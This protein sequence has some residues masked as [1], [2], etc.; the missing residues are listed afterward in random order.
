VHTLR[1]Q[2][3]DVTN[4]TLIHAFPS[5]VTLQLDRM[6]V[7][8]LE[9]DAGSTSLPLQVW[10]HLDVFRGDA[11][12]L[13]TAKDHVRKG[14]LLDV[15][16]SV[17]APDEEAALLDVLDQVQPEILRIS[18]QPKNSDGG[19]FFEISRL[20]ESAPTVQIL[21]IDVLCFVHNNSAQGQMDFRRICADVDAALSLLVRV[22][23]HIAFRSHSCN[24]PS[25]PSNC[26]PFIRFGISASLVMTV[27][28]PDVRKKGPPRR[29]MTSEHSSKASLERFP[30]C[31]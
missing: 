13:W 5:L 22:E 4:S 8:D 24:R 30:A 1:L 7:L 9:G 21:E 12:S 3:S 14:V 18:T 31:L 10:P 25:F 6:G 15:S 26:P 29:P 23:N 17:K 16:E 19:M 27:K 11:L 20:V 2:V 28:M